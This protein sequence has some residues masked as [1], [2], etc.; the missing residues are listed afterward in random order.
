MAFEIDSDDDE[1]G[2]A[3]VW[4]NNGVH[5]SKSIMTLAEDA[6]LQVGDHAAG[7]TIN[8][9]NQVDD[10]N[11]GELKFETSRGGT[12]II[13]SD[14]Q[15]ND[16]VGKISFWG[17]DDG[18]PSAQQY[19][20]ILCK[21]ND[22]SDGAE[23]GRMLLQVASHDGELQPGLQMISGNAED[24]VDVTIGNDSNSLTTVAGALTA[25]KAVSVNASSGQSGKWLGMQI[26]RRTITT[27]E[28]NSMHSTPIEIVPAQ[29][30]DTII[31]PVSGR[32]RVDRAATQTNSSADFN[33][34]YADLEPGNFFATSLMHI[35]RIM[36]NETGDREYNLTGPGGEVAQALTE[37]VNKA[38]EMSFDA[39]TTTNC[40]TSIDVFLIYYVI[41]IS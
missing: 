7:G 11:S 8:I 5:G 6:T 27:G 28:A 38:V 17:V 41:D 39:A 1:T 16:E 12:G 35:R 29:G 2:Q 34:H 31:I 36:W 30:A 10:A 15:D 24:I 21:A 40:F 33:M 37:S 22:V 25:S 26:A 20:E 23:E 32:M 3:F 9:Y 13:G 19:G 18:T 14:G 4:M